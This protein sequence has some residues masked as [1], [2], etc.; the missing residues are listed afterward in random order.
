M[1]TINNGWVTMKD[2]EGEPFH[3]NIDEKEEN[4]DKESKIIKDKLQQYNDMIEHWHFMKKDKADT[5]YQEAVMHCLEKQLDG[6]GAKYP[7]FDYKNKA[8]NSL[9]E[10]ILDTLSESIAEAAVNH[11]GE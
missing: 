8:H 4:E 11:L 7:K 5:S 10:L 2:K 3:V 1:Q 9:D 6:L